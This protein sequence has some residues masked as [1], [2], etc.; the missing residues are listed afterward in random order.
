MQSHVLYGNESIYNF[1]FGSGVDLVIK[2]LKEY[3]KA[4]FGLIF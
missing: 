1:T 2:Y 3:D 4:A